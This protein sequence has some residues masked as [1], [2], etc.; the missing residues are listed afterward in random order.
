M[1]SRAI[2]RM[3]MLFLDWKRRFLRWTVDCGRVNR[4]SDVRCVQGSVLV[5]VMWL[6][7]GLAV[8]AVGMSRSAGQQVRHWAQLRDRAVC[9]DLLLGVLRVASGVVAADADRSVDAMC[10]LWAQPRGM[11]S[12]GVGDGAMGRCRYAIVDEQA[13]LNLNTASEEALNQLPEWDRQMAVSVLAW[14][15]DASLDAAALEEEDKHYGGEAV[16]DWRLPYPR[17]GA[18]L[19]SVEELWLV[20]GMTAER[21]AVAESLATVFG[22]GAVNLNTASPEVMELLGVS[23][24]VAR[25]V[26]EHIAGSDGVVATDDDQ[27]IR[28]A[29]D[30]VMV[31]GVDHEAAAQLQQ[32]FNRRVLSGQTNAFCV[33][34][35]AWMEDEPR[36]ER[37]AVAVVTRRGEE[38]RCEVF[39]YER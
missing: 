27:P 25:V 13:R 32:L 37:R 3:M 15:G 21:F 5:I 36:S 38:T 9:G 12:E 16:G 18:P 39:R 11:T 14:R 19:E 20:R 29:G 2:C 10:E 22:D 24:D 1:G 6:V 30:V 35:S 26:A 34:V 7:M 17:K 31:S 8:L 23:G 28:G 33:T 4:S